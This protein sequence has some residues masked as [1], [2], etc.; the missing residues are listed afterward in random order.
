MED[1]KYSNINNT[2]LQDELYAYKIS[3]AIKWGEN[4]NDEEFKNLSVNK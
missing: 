4:N 2:I 1:E 3:A